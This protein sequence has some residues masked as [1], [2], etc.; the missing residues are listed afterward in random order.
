MLAM[1]VNDDAVILDKRVAFETIASKLAPTGIMFDT[2]SVFTGSLWERACSGRRSDD[3][4]LSHFAE[5]APSTRVW[6]S[7]TNCLRCSSLTKL[8]A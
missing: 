1:D 3:G 5:I 6:A 7:A 8:S 4:V 2:E